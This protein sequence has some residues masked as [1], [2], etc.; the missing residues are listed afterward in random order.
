[1]EKKMFRDCTLS[2]LDREFGLRE[3]FKST[4]LEHWLQTDVPLTELEQ[5]I[6]INYQ[7]LLITH[8]TAWNE[9]ELSQQFIGPVFGLAHLTE[10]YRFRLF[11]EHKIK[12]KI[13]G[14]NH[15]FEL[16]GEPDGI[17]ATGY[18]EPGV[19]MFAFN[20]YKRS[21]NH[22]GDPA[23]QALAA[24]LVGQALNDNRQPIYGAYVIG[25]DWRFMRINNT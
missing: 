4:V 25:S 8:V 1:M 16:G 17:I 20:E 23:G 12:A 9:R 5:A 11:A 24:M 14:V 21:V 10:L 13:T 15:E 2:F 22:Q 6:L 7:K 18:R 3:E 19:P